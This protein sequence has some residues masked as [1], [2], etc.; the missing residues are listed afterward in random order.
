LQKKVKEGC[1]TLFDNGVHLV[2]GMRNNMKNRLISKQDKLLYLNKL[3][4]YY[5]LSGL[6]FRRVPSN[7]QGVA[8]GLSYLRASPYGVNRLEYL[9]TFLKQ[10]SGY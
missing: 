10:N 2:T 5:A 1:I 8:V 9:Y 4:L 3:L 6:I 7:T